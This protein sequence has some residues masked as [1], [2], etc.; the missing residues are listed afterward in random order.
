VTL[1]GDGIDAFQALP[2]SP[3]VVKSPGIDM[4]VPLLRLAAAQGACVIDELELGWRAAHTPV[5][6]VTGTNG[7]STTCVLVAAILEAAGFTPERVGNT[8]FGPPLSAAGNGDYLVCEVSSFQLEATTAFLPEF[9][10]FTNL[11]LEHLSRHETMENYARAKRSMFVRGQRTCGC[12]IINADD[13]WGRDIAD[14]VRMAGGRVVTYGFSSGA[15]I[16]IANAVWSLREA[17][18]S[19][20][21]NHRALTLHSRL[22]GH[23]NALN[24]GA[25]VT[26]A[27]AAGLNDDQITQGVLAASPPPGRWELID[28]GQSFDVIVDYAHTPDGITKFLQA[29]LQV[30]R[31]R[32]SLLRVVFGAVGLPDRDKAHGCGVAAASLSDHL[33]LTT[34]TAPRSSRMLRL[35]ELRDAVRRKDGFEI[36]LDRRKAIG[37]AIGS[38][39]AGDVVAILG[40]GAL[41]RL[42]LDAAGSVCP[43]SDREVAIEALRLG[44]TCDS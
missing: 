23:H 8:E 35:M 7:K 19:I 25:A 24:I 16:R 27:I 40:L 26:F 18:T 43:F 20:V 15:D 5:A 11:T 3:T 21:S 6:A 34:G 42:V 22:P 4:H 37:R 39:R 36:I 10:L 30:T 28:E 41:R 38:A 9:A 12:A 33:I 29:A 44:Q 32:Q 17:R 1:G 31:A 2:Q 14:A 13:A